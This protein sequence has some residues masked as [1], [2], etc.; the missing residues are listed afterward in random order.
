M[1]TFQVSI[2][3]G[4]APPKKGPGKKAPPK[5]GGGGGGRPKLLGDES[6]F[7]TGGMTY[8][9]PESKGGGGKKCR[10]DD[11]SPCRPPAEKKKSG[12]DYA[13]LG[14]I[15]GPIVGVIILCVLYSK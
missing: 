4:K 10:E 14:M 1:G 11:G 15:I 12:T 7:G 8:I 6:T 13:L 5:K 9:A 3:P 2:M